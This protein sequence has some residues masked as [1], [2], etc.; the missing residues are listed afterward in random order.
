VNPALVYLMVRTV[1]GRIVRAIKLLRQPKYLVGVIVFVAWMV[2]WVGSAFVRPFDEDR[3]DIQFT[4]AELLFETM[5]DAIPALQMLVALLFALLMS[6]WWLVPW[7]RMALNLTEAEIHMLTP[8]PLKR[9]HLIQYAT[10]KS[11]P[12]I[13][14]GC[15]MMTIFLGYGGPP[16]RAGWFAAFWV[17]LTIWDLHAKGRALWLEKQKEL[18]PGRAWRNR[19]L[20]VGGIV[21]YWIVLGTALNALVTDMVAQWPAPDREVLDFSD[22]AEWVVGDFRRMLVLY[23]ERVQT[24]LIGWLLAPFRWITAP[25]FVSAPGAGTWLRATGVIMPLLLLVAQNE[26]VVRSQAKFEEAALAHARREANKKGAGARYWK[27]SLRRRRRVP[28]RLTPHGPPELAVL[29]KNSL[30]VTRFSYRNLATFGLLLIAVAIAIPIAFPFFRPAPF[31]IMSIALM[32]LLISPFTGSQ[33]Y[34]NDLR[35]DLLRLEMVRPWPIEG[36]KLFAAESLSPAV[37]AFMTALLAAAL[38]MAMDIYLMVNPAEISDYRLTPEGLSATLRAPRPLLMPLLLLAVLPMLAAITC[39]STTLQNL[40]VLL[41]PGWVQLGNDRQQGAAAFGQNM[42]MFFGLGLVSLLCL[43][44]AG[45][46]VALIVA[47]QLWI[48]DVPLVEWEFP[49]LGI[50]AATPVFTIVALIVRAGG[51]VWNRLDPSREI[52]E[53]AR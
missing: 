41:F 39:L 30:I 8:M 31:I 43:L 5:G 9:R 23:G 3:G 44:P 27:T 1:R 7:S 25:L 49:V 46:I 22:G 15:L 10:L 42:L 13:L 38:V 21:V 33:N 20:L 48:F 16:A 12:G 2:F 50:I 11:Q 19:L 14:F 26:W 28:F 24:G 37:F 40:L 51:R 4:N 53:G 52:L 29:W 34:R 6:L 35:S 47:A 18:P 36:W 45:L 17:T 32:T